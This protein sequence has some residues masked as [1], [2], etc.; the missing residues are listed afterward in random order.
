MSKSLSARF[1]LCL[2]ISLT[3]SCV[4]N[5]FD[6]ILVLLNCV[7]IISDL[8]SSSL[9]GDKRRSFS[10][11]SSSAYFCI[12]LECLSYVL[13]I[14]KIINL[15]IVELT[16]DLTKLWRRWYRRICLWAKVSPIIKDYHLRERSC[17]EIMWRETT[18]YLGNLPYLLPQ[19]RDKGDLGLSGTYSMMDAKQ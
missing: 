1:L 13:H 9:L 14:M 7:L 16:Y 4:W 5:C 17:N 3:F 15:E 19:H 18:C 8:S 11:W 6:C 10:F 2:S 12:F